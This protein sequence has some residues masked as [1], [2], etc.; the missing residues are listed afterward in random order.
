MGPAAAYRFDM[1]AR[2]VITAPFPTLEETAEAYGLSAAE[3]KRA[4]KDIEWLLS[5]PVGTRRRGTGQKARRA[6]TAARSG[7]AKK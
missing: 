1:S 3:R 5:T 7:T 6:R 4:A 2:V